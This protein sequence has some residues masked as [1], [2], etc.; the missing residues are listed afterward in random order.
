MTFCKRC[1]LDHPPNCVKIRIKEQVVRVKVNYQKMS[2]NN[3]MFLAILQ[4]NM[5]ARRGAL[6]EPIKDEKLAA[7]Y[8]MFSSLF[9]DYSRIHFDID[10]DA[11]DGMERFSDL[12]EKVQ[13]WRRSE[14]F[15]W[16]V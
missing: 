10:H 4:R 1:H 9:E 16:V 7:E 8:R 3:F 11:P 14:D 6:D 15:L 2:A 12:I 13:R 5:E